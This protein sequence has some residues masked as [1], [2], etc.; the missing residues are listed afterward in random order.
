[1]LLSICIATRNQK[2]RL[3]LLLRSIETQITDD[4]EVVV[5]DESDDRGV[6]LGSHS[7]PINMPVQYH[8]RESIFGID[9]AL[10]S[11]LRMAKGKYVWLF[12]DDILNP[13]AL[14]L[15][16]S[17]IS[18][19]NDLAVILVN[20][21]EEGDP[22]LKTFGATQ[23]KIFKHPDE[24]LIYDIGLLG[25]ISA[26]ILRRDLAL[27]TLDTAEDYIGSSFISLCVTLEVLGAGGQIGIIGESCFS[28]QAKPPGEQRW[29][30][31]A[32]VFGINLFVICKRHSH[33]F[34]KVA[35]DKALHRNMVRVLKAVI[36][37]RAMGFKTGFASRDFNKYRLIK[38]YWRSITFWALFLVTLLPDFALDL[39]YQFSK[40]IRRYF[41][42]SF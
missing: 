23:S 34:S 6:E 32:E 14:S 7:L 39:T 22:N 24:I 27:V 1:M 5:L 35:L 29:Y 8:H 33:G 26:V 9:G 2:D 12:G 28:S 17:F 13:E 11:L 10:L 19:H 30:N 15:V 37:E 38:L 18:K 41:C 31:Q 25:F 40:R 16:T 3:K 42:E 20:S 4:I 21:E 36:F